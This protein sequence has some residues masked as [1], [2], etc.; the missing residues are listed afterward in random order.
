MPQ[1]SVIELVS[2]V[3]EGLKKKGLLFLMMGL[4]IVWQ[5]Y[6]N[7]QYRQANTANH[8]QLLEAQKR[9]EIRI[10]LLEEQVSSC[11]KER[12][13]DMS[14]KIQKLV[15]SNNSLIERNLDALR[16]R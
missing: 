3:L 11:Y 2:W 7:Y 4:V 9:Q 15:E 13:D 14:Q 6:D 12:Y 1:G 5:G 8:N 10:N 16:H